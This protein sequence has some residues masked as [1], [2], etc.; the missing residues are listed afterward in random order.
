MS[1]T[2]INCLL[3][4]YKILKITFYGLS[5]LNETKIKYYDFMAIVCKVE[6]KF[7]SI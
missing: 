3:D 7:Q 1:H 2:D 5:N 4:F 6:I